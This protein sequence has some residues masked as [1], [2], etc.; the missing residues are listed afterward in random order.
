MNESRQ[1]FAWA[2][3]LTSFF[4][5][6]A[7][8]GGTV[9]GISSFLRRSTR[10]LPISLQANQGTVVVYQDGNASRAVRLGDSP[11]TINPNEHVQTNAT[12]TGLLLVY[13][14]ESPEIMARIQVYGNSNLQIHQ[15]TSPRFT[16]SNSNDQTLILRLVSG[17]LKL[18]VPELPDS[19][20]VVYIETPQGV[21]LT[22]RN[23]GQYSLLV[24]PAETQVAVQ[25]GQALIT[26]QGEE[27]PLV[28][29]QR[30]TIADGSSPVGPLN[31]ERDLLQNGN[32]ADGLA[33]W[34]LIRGDI[35]RPDQPAGEVQVRDISG[36]PT[37]RFSRVGLGHADVTVRQVLNQDVTDYQSLRLE[38]TMRIINQSIGVCGVEGSE[39]PLTIALDYEDANGADR[40]WQQG[41]F[42]IGEI[43]AN[44]TP[45]VC[46]FCPAPL[47][48]HIRV[49]QSQ[50]VFYE[51]RNLLEQLAQQGIPAQRINAVRLIAAGH[52]FEVEVVAVS[53]LAEE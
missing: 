26:A 32:F 40:T 34:I 10:P 48:E 35:E 24:S 14:P 50:L 25:E 38:V 30:A 20:F 36:A 47:N 13:P 52:T 9:L 33:E 53:L 49:P 18:I 27:L 37:L 22:V 5:C 11:Q 16:F 28:T 19:R 7:L 4:F 17:R 15:A 2:V 42:A 39:C 21:E 45:D 44:S 12:D 41:Y 1:R 8:A 31:S 29:D 23:A 51:S 6:M 43:D 3:L 46:R